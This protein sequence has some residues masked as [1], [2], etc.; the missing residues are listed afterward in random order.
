MRTSDIWQLDGSD[1]AT[2]AL[3]T[4][5]SLPEPPVTVLLLTLT[6]FDQTV[7]SVGELRP[8]MT[9]MLLSLVL[10]HDPVIHP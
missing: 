3:I 10:Q 1:A 5:V 7:G 4:S 6:P 2:P 9:Y 8:A